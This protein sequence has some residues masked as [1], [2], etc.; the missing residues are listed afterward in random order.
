MQILL[1]FLESLLYKCTMINNTSKPTSP[2]GP[3]ADFQQ[4]MERIYDHLYANGSVRTAGG[5]AYEVGKVLY[6]GMFTEEV[7]GKIP[8]FNL[9][10]SELNSL[11][12]RDKSLCKRTAE[13][14]KENF[15][16]MN[17]S[18][19][20]YEDGTQIHLNDFDLCYVCTQLNGIVLSDKRRDTFGDAVEVFRYEWAR[21]FGGQFFT[22]PRVTSLAMVLLDFDPRRGDDL[23][24]ICAGSGGFLLAG[25]N[26]IRELLEEDASVSSVESE[27]VK[28][29]RRSL[30]GQEVDPE[31]CEIGN[32]TLMGR[33]GARRERLVSQGDS[34][35]L[36]AFESKT[37]TL[38]FGSHL[39]A[40]SNPPFGTKITMKDPEI[41]EHYELAIQGGSTS[42]QNKQKSLSPRSLDILFLERN[43]KMLKP[44][45]GRLAIVLPY[46]LLSGP[47]TLF[48]REWLLK[49]TQLIAVVDL[50][51]ET[52]QPYTGTKTALLVVKRREKMVENPRGD[53]DFHIFMS[54]PRWIGHDRRGYPVYRRAPDGKVTNEV[55]TDFG[56]VRR[57]F[58][59]FQD[60]KDPQDAH[61][62][63]FGVK[64]SVIARDPL[65]RINAL[66]HQPSLEVTTGWK[67]SLTKRDWTVVKLRELVKDIFYPGR[68]KRNYVEPF[69]GAIP[70][71]GGSNITEFISR[72]DKWLAPDEPKL[73]GLQV[74]S[75]WLLVTRSGTTGIVSSV[76]K[77]WNG[78]AMSEH[79]I[80][81]VPN[82]EKVHP[83]YLIAFLRSKYGQEQLARG[84]FGSVIDEIT[85]EYVGDI[86]VPIP[87]SK[88]EIEDVIEMVRRGEAA[89][90][91]GIENCVE[92]VELLNSELS[93]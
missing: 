83:E 61:R 36:E 49:N 78:F 9:P 43:V 18:W 90:Q 24:D 93:T 30:R 8:A 21:R 42:S 19:Q 70:F 23:I 31:V 2:Q 32:A 26:R 10:R 68:F 35:T 5:I 25:L 48:V 55:L 3:S 72:T 80:R 65:L 11:F 13:Q 4:C 54:I 20:L 38:R 75:G 60:G 15:K 77:A 46:Q 84:V 62:T 22:D 17:L 86:D 89:R 91:R 85:P 59:L 69:P 58:K 14:V 29:A 66:F 37:S 27:I 76:P 51:A 82:P 57:A 34:L 53:E 81:I 28:L 45:K 16:W 47:Q 56:D 6:T 74:F 67:E 41:L 87:P 40:A 1:D 50:P 88:N 63:S 71:L 52:F 39:C 92:A 73:K 12:V 64:F 79:V 44:G 33:L 7:Q